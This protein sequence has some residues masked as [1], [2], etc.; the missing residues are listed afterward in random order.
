MDAFNFPRQQSH[1]LLGIGQIL[2]NL[3]QVM[4]LHFRPGS[5]ER[6]LRAFGWNNAIDDQA[7]VMDAYLLSSLIARR[8]SL[9]DIA[10]GCRTKIKLV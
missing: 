9:I 6:V 10:S 8:V 5:K 3:F 4:G 2:F 7:V 1:E